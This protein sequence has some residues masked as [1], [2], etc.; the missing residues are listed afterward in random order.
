[1]ENRFY[2]YEHWRP[3][4]DEC[5]YVGK[6]KGKRAQVMR[7]RNPHHTAIQ[8]KLNSLGMQ[9][10]VRIVREE[11]SHEA[12]CQLEIDRIAHWRILNIG[13]ANYS[14]GGEGGNFDPIPEVRRKISLANMGHKKRLGAKLPQ[15]SK[16]A[17]RL[18]QMRPEIKAAWAERSRLGPAASAKRV[19]CI[20]DGV[21][22]PSAS[23]A[24][25]AYGATK[26]AVIELCNGYNKY[27]KT[28]A[29]RRFEY[30][31]ALT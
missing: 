18:A 7:A 3:D 1:M 12:A 6:G 15:E 27:R 20:D 29:R 5:F 22:Y 4:R 23:E 16:D 25:R 13:L 2:V 28:A 26:S 17:I 10:D 21:E 9:V 11:L 31:G 24:A 8:I 14:S 19:R 30:V